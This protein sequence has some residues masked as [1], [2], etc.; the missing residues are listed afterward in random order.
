MG[1]TASVSPA[2]SP[3]AHKKLN[4][5][6]FKV[7]CA[8]QYPSSELYLAL[9]DEKGLVE[10]NVLQSLKD[11]TEREVLS[12]FLEYCNGHM[13]LAQF[14]QFCVETKLLS[15]KSFS[16]RDAENL[17]HKWAKEEIVNYYVLRHHIFLEIASI[18]HT[19]PFQIMLKI[20]VCEG[21]ASKTAVSQEAIAAPVVTITTAVAVDAPP[22]EPTVS[23]EDFLAALSPVQVELLRGACIQL[24][25]CARYALAAKEAAARKE[26]RKMSATAPPLALSPPSTLEEKNCQD[27]FS[28]FSSGDEMSLQEFLNFCHH[29]TLIAPSSTFSSKK[30]FTK[31]DAQNIFKKSLAMFYDP[32]TKGYLEGVKFGKR[33]LFPVFRLVVLP[34]VAASKR[35]GIDDLLRQLMRVKGKLS[36]S[37]VDDPL[38]EQEEGR[39]RRPSLSLLN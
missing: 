8:S 3:A 2:S 7:L 5:E 18:Q 12:L 28:H 30:I 25:K 11:P 37:V 17:F 4:E 9:H 6:E 29:T 34:E 26:R 16:R 33:I 23:Q 19:S 1:A 39:E 13:T 31:I 22:I 32:K 38:E 36:I 20:A 15:K 10:A 21:P 14:I 35:V 27:L 24:Q